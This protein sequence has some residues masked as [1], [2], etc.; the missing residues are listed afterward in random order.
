LYSGRTKANED[1]SLT[2]Y[3][4]RSKNAEDV[5]H[6]QSREGNTDAASNKASRQSWARLIQKIYEVDPIVCAKCS[7]KMRI[8]AVITDPD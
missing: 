5:K 3:G 1:G 8:A 7:H 2:K 4:H 6:E